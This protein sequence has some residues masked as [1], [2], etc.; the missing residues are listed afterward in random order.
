MG[1]KAES[2]PCTRDAILRRGNDL[3]KFRRRVANL[4]LFALG[5]H[6]PFPDTILERG[7]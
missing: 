7:Y 2:I 1:A 4:E 5:M 3:R 6:R